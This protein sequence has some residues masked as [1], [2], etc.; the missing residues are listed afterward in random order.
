MEC[1]LETSVPDWLIDHPQLL[2]L[3]EELQIDYCC[4]GK[5]LEFAC[6]QAGVDPRYVLQRLKSVLD[7]TSP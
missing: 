5:S 7:S 6:Q 4:G 1:D 2:S 3:F